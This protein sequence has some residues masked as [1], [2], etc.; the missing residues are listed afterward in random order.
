MNAPLIEL[1]VRRGRLIERIATQRASLVRCVQPVARV[2]HVVDRTRGG[3]R[4]TTNRIKNHPAIVATALAL[5]VILKPSR[6]WRWGR[7]SFVAWRAWR[8]LRERFHAFAW[9]EP[10][11]AKRSRS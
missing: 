4:T 10:L 9:L 5:L 8:A 11:Q 1:A 6:A 7:R 3:V 2:L